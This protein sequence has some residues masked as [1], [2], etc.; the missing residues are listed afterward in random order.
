MKMDQM[1]KCQ[2]LA[3]QFLALT[4]DVRQRY[5]YEKET[6]VDFSGTKETAALKRASMDL[7]RAL[8]N[9]RKS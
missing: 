5:E 4:I 3:E 6:S 1:M 7:T 8:A 2:Y 9:L